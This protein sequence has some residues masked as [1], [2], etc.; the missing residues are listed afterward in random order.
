MNAEMSQFPSPKPSTFKDTI[1]HAPD[2]IAIRKWE[3]PKNLTTK[4]EACEEKVM[5]QR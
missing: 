2:P 3:N 5:L 1:T 4:L